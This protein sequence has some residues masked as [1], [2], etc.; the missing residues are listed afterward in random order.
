M[1]DLGTAIFDLIRLIH[2]EDAEQGY[3]A[4]SQTMAD[5]FTHASRSDIVSAQKILE[6]DY[7]AEVTRHQASIATVRRML[8]LIRK[9]I[10][11]GVCVVKAIAEEAA[12]ESP[13]MTLYHIELS[14]WYNPM[15][16][17]WMVLFRSAVEMHTK[18]EPAGPGWYICFDESGPQG[19]PQSLV[20]S[21]PGVFPKAMRLVEETVRRGRGH[22]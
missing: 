6:D 17:V 22:A 15:P 4:F 18:W 13:V 10:P 3:D 8:A 12:T 9:T 21:F 5:L 19:T 2:F 7:R 1:T 11:D 20:D 16:L 14:D